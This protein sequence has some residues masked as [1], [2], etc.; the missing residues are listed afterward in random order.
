MKTEEDFL[1]KRLRGKYFTI[2]NPFENSGFKLWADACNLKNQNI[3]EPFAGSNNLIYMLE[4]MKLCNAYTSF[5]I[6]PEDKNV[7]Y[8]DT[9]LNFPIGFDVC[10]TNPPYLAKNSAKR[11][12][13]N[14]PICEYDDLYKFALKKCLDNCQNVAAIIPASFLNS[15]LFRQRLSCY[16]LLS[17]K[18]FNDTEHPVCLALFKQ[19]S[20][21]VKIYHNENYLGTLEEFEK[22]LPSTMQNI[23]ISFN[24]KK[25]N[26]GLYAIDNTVEPSIYFCEGSKID[27]GR[28]NVS[29]R[30][31][32]RIKIETSNTTKLIKNLNDYLKDF[33]EKTEDIFLT[34]FKGLR[35][36]NKY[37]RRLDFAMTRRIINYICECGL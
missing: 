17:S 12:G 2:Y 1:H 25:G 3:L 37:R 19:S 22:S 6:E 13:L 26:I 15:G 33:R 7:K 10:V 29:S 35:R 30:S 5:D 20:S 4:Q 23:D 24:D 27:G 34:P 31:I 9:L 16:I 28:I 32:T 18:M 8:K 14:F 36:D 11:R 21:S